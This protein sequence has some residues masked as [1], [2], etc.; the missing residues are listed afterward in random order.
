[1]FLRLM[2][3]KIRSSSADQVAKRMSRRLIPHPYPIIPSPVELGLN[4]IGHI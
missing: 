2:A 4:K 3:F 1:M